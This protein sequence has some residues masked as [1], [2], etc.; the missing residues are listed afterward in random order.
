M[1]SADMIF[2]EHQTPAEQQDLENCLG[3]TARFVPLANA[4]TDE[5]SINDLCSDGL[6]PEQQRVIYCNATGY[7]LQAR[8][9]LPGTLLAKT[10]FRGTPTP[11]SRAVLQ[12]ILLHHL[13]YRITLAATSP[14]MT[15]ERFALLHQIP[16]DKTLVVPLSMEDHSDPYATFPNDVI[17]KRLKQEHTR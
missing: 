7:F 16:R 17:L 6:S 15:S 12:T 13:G 2:G 8:H 1:V 5:Y 4:F 14:L 9:E 10:A 11:F 3:G